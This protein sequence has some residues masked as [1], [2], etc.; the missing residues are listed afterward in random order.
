MSEPIME[1]LVQPNVLVVFTDD[2]AQWALGSGVFVDPCAFGSEARLMRGERHLGSV[3]HG[4][5][6]QL[7]VPASS[8]SGCAAGSIRWRPRRRKEC[9]RM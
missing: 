3:G 6:Y 1:V 2:H 7:C 5:R 9:E 4:D 8:T